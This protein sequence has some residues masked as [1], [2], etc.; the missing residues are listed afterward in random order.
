VDRPL[1]ARR[2]APEPRRQG[3]DCRERK[4]A[5][6]DNDFGMWGKLAAG[7]AGIGGLILVRFIGVLGAAT[8]ALASLSIGGLAT[9]LSVTF[10]CE[11]CRMAIK[12]LDADER[13]TL[14]KARGLLLAVS[15]GLVIATL[16]CAYLYYLV[17]QEQE[18]NEPSFQ[19]F[20]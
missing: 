10:R 14:W 8:V 3:C 12:D 19:S 20:E 18:K 7:V 11:G 17:L 15:I 4:D 1:P 2:P 5:Y 16:V 6:V 9:T 13:Q